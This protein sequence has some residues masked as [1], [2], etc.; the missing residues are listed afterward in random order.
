MELIFVQCVHLKRSGSASLEYF[1]FLRTINRI[2][3]RIMPPPIIPN[4][5]LVDVDADVV[6]RVVE[7]VE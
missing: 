4:A 1:F 3:A 7:K 6:E 5:H 2:A